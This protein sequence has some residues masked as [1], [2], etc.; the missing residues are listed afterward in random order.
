MRIALYTRSE[1]PT[2]G[3]LT[4]L[5]DEM[6]VDY[7][8]NP[9]STSGSDFAI[10]YGGDGTFLSSV[11]KMGHDFI[12]VMG[13]NSGRLEFLAT[14]SKDRAEDAIRQLIAGNFD[15]DRR[16]MIKIDCREL[17]SDIP[18]RALN[19]F[20]IQKSGTAMI[21]ITVTIDHQQVGSYWADGIIVST[22]TGSTAYSMSVGGAILT[23]GCRAFIISPI[24]P[25]NL[26][27]RPLVIADC[28]KIELT[29]ESRLEC[30]AIATVDNREYGVMSGTQ[31]ELHRSKYDLEIVKLKEANFYK[32]LREKLLWGVD[33][34]N[35]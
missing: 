17:P 14:V 16:S 24:A 25:H 19:E 28:S 22:P 4:S 31:F 8:I 7:A 29:V 13:I 5:L 35:Q 33:P 11:R 10:S 9:T 26:N 2:V 23:P 3:Q 1:N 15:I 12:P 21:R 30:E 20:T 32:T 6:N 18:R 34:R 27:I